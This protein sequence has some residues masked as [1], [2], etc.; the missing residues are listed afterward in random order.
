[1][2]K[3]KIIQNLLPSLPLKDIALGKKFLE[4]R[5]FEQLQDLIN[6]AIYK[7]HKD[8]CSENPSEKYKDIDLDNLQTLKAE[9]DMYAFLLVIDEDENEY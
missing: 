6:S 9:V 7:V 1:M 3:L 8:R 4:E 5:K 2:S